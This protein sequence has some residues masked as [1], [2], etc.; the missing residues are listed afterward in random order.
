E[1][2]AAYFAAREA[3]LAAAQDPTNEELREGIAETYTGANLELTLKQ[4]DELATTASFAE[5][6]PDSPPSAL[7]L[8]GPVLVES[9]AALADM[10]ICEVNSERYLQRPAGAAEPVVIRD[11]PV[12]VRVF[13]RLE[14][15]DGAW[16]SQ[17]GDVLARVSTEDECFP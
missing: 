6:D 17:S 2:E 12:V 9:D 10:V 16:K 7:F 8:E 11:E 5:V 15:V 14:F 3:Y 1:V 13:V 4:L